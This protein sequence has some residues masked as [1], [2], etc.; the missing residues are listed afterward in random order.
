MQ[1]IATK[2][3]L[4]VAERGFAQIPNYLIQLNLFVHDD[5]KLSPAEMV[6]LLQLV[7][8]WWKK[9]EMPFPS[10]NTLAERAG[11]SE[12]QVQRSIKSLE[13]KGYLKKAKKKIKGVIASNVYDLSP[14]VRILGTVA[15]HFVNKHPR[16]I[17]TPRNAGRKEKREQTTVNHDL[18]FED[19]FQGTDHGADDFECFIWADEPPNKRWHFTI[20]K[21]ILEMLGG[22]PSIV[23][24]HNVA[25]CN[26]NRARILAACEVAH[27]EQPNEDRVVLQRQ[28]FR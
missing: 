13:Q 2:W 11:I 9:D 26:A 10:M 15:E 6:V 21:T 18:T 8:T 25:I 27:N 1:D 20:G 16:K 4:E 14:L 3:G 23:P 17:S 24:Q 5:H 12:R 22:T 7:A 28:H 19:E